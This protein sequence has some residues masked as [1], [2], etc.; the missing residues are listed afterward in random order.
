MKLNQ[1]V[2]AEVKTSGKKKKVLGLDFF[3]GG[4]KKRKREEKKEKDEENKVK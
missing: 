3:I 4:E 1:I 2:L